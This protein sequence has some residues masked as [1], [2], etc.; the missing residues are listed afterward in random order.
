VNHI[1]DADVAD[2]PPY[3]QVAISFAHWLLEVAGERPLLVAYN[4]DAFDLPF[5]LH[6]NAAVDPAAFP[7]FGVVYSSDAL[8]CAKKAFTRDQVGGSFRQAA[9]YN[10]LF[11]TEPAAQ[12][13]SQ[14]DV[15]ALTRIVEHEALV[16]LITA[17][18][19]PLRDIT[20]QSMRAAGGGA[21]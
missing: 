21:V 16:Q 10:F 17:S 5:L 2:A 6:K 9:L 7:R 12:H 3:E 20:G 11:G 1:Y 18:A 4:G 19:R 8:C 15:E 14:G 13:T